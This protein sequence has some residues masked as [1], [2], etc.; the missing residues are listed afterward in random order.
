M[1]TIIECARQNGT[2]SNSSWRNIFNQPLEIQRNDVILVKNVFLDTNTNTQSA[3]VLED[4]VPLKLEFGYYMTNYELTDSTG[5][6]E[7][8]V[9][10]R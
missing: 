7:D 5:G 6:S 10:Y 9:D 2:G 3:I 1:T 4:D 8:V